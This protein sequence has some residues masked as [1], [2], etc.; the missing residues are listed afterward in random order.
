[1]AT[2]I[3]SVNFMNHMDMASNR[4][5]DFTAPSVSMAAA[6]M[7]AEEAAGTN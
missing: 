6:S 2:L 7:A 3:T 1:M 4:A 5:E